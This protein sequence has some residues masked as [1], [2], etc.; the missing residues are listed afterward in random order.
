MTLWPISSAM[1]CASVGIDH[2]VDRMHLA[3]LHQ[4][5]DDV[6]GALRH[7]V[8]KFLD[9]DRL[10]DDDLAAHLLGRHLEALGLLLETFGA[11][12]ESGHRTAALALFLGQGI[13]HREAA[14]ALV[15]IGLRARRNRRLEFTFRRA[16]GPR[17]PR[18]IVVIIDGALGRHRRG[19]HRNRRR[20]HHAGRRLGRQLLGGLL[21]LAAAFFLDPVTGIVLGLAPGRGLALDALA[22]IELAAAAGFL[23][24]PLAFIGLTQA[25]IR[26][27]PVAGFLLLG[28]QRTQDDAGTASSSRWCLRALLRGCLRRTLRHLRLRLKSRGLGF[29]CRGLV[30]AQALALG[31]HHHGLGPAMG[32]TLLHP[33]LLDRRDASRSACRLQCA[34]HRPCGHYRCCPSYSLFRSLR[35]QRGVKNRQSAAR[36]QRAF[37]PARPLPRQHVPHL[38]VQMPNPIHRG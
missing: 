34:R 32:K 30:V 38:T 27:G 15:G 35:P 5:L 33:A 1:S 26:Q 24:L 3:L 7:A 36:R 11:A 29:C 23:F 12:A 9:G 10:G 8:G 25:R 17:G 19:L 37:R 13:D 28:R 20:R 4:Q 14:A 22:L 2:I 18:P 16:A 31:L 6:D 21:G